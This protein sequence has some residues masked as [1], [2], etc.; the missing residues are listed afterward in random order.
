MLQQIQSQF[1]PL[2]YEGI[3]FQQYQPLQ[4][5]QRFVREYTNE[6]YKMPTRVQ[7]TETEV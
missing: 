2:N 1:L 7:L 6:F 3:L 5:G 4:Q